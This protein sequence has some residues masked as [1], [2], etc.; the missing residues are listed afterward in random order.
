[1]TQARECDGISTDYQ[2]PTWG[3]PTRKR[4][5]DKE[6]PLLGAEQEQ[7]RSH[8]TG[9]PPTRSCKQC[10]AEIRELRKT[11]KTADILRQASELKHPSRTHLEQYLRYKIRRNYRVNTLRNTLLSGKQLLAFLTETGTERLEDLTAEDLETIIEREQDRGLKPRTV[12]SKLSLIKAFIHFLIKEGVVGH[13]VLS[14]KIRI[15][16]PDKL[17]RAMDPEEIKE[18]V[19]T[20]DTVRD[21]AMVMV[22]WRTGMR[23]GELLNTK[24]EEVNLRKQTIAVMEGEKNRIGRVVYMSEDARAA[25]E[26]WMK[27]R[28]PQKVYLFY[29][30]GKHTLGYAAARVRFNKYL[31]TAGLAHKGYTIHCLRH[32]FATE[33]LNAG[34]RLECLQQ[35]LGH[36]CLEM[37]LQYARLTDVTRQQEY[38]QAMD[39]IERGQHY[40]PYQLDPELQAILEEKKLLRKHD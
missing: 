40:G 8:Q 28:D 14:R 15:K 23:I 3:K 24:P 37:T 11:R 31:A 5:L 26:A 36:S 21:R 29:A 7:L 27:Q 1:M 16:L 32:S 30:Q 34:M 6:E 25:L 20:I 39:L 35:L 33:M 18:L 2:R 17:P 4:C 22:L 9:I 38:F 13:E 19:R 10:L 12:H